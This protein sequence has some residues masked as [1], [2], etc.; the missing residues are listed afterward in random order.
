MINYRYICL[1]FSVLLFSIP[2]QASTHRYTNRTVQEIAKEKDVKCL[3]RNI[4]HEAANEPEEGMV[5]VGVVT[6]NRVKDPDYPKT[7]C[8]VVTQRKSAKKLRNCQFTWV[9]QRIA[10]PNTIDPRWQKSVHIAKKLAAGGYPRWRTKYANAM[11]YH[12][13]YVHPGWNY[14]RIT[15]IGAHIYYKSL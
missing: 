12:A 5:A 3:A 14:P 13:V 2:T 15:R 4:Y 9:C 7:V 10:A 6:L 1:A 8:G 11:H